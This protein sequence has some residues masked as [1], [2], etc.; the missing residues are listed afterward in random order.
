MPSHT[1][2]AAAVVA[3]RPATIDHIAYASSFNQVHHYT[4]NM[5]AMA[6]Y[7]CGE[8]GLCPD[9]QARAAC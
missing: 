9:Y 5:E 4:R 6:E 2:A 3:A 7:I 8:L 1:V